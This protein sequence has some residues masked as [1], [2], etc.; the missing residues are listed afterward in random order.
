MQTNL[1]TRLVPEPSW[2][3]RPSLSPHALCNSS[4]TLA[5]S[6]QSTK[7]QPFPQLCLRASLQDAC[8]RPPMAPAQRLQG[9]P[10]SS[11]ELATV[12]WEACFCSPVPFPQPDPHTL[13]TP[14]APPKLTSL[15][16]TLLP[17]AREYLFPYQPNLLTFPR[18]GPRVPLQPL[19][20]CLAP[21]A[22]PLHVHAPPA[23][24]PAGRSRG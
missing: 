1:P 5:V 21:P 24:E 11:T 8:T 10:A 20:L 9:F 23:A 6:V 13:A 14:T 18:W 7:T 12:T 4:M 15:F 17:T 16:P 2:P 3:S 22:L 19:H